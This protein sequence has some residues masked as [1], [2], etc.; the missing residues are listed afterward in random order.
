MQLDL[1]TS[2][3]TRFSLSLE[4]I[5]NVK[6][7]SFKAL[8][9]KL[10]SVKNPQLIIIGGQEG[11]FKDELP[12][13]ALTELS[14][15]AMVLSKEEL[16]KY[17]PHFAEIQSH[18]PDML[19]VFTDDLANLLL[20]NLENEAI[21]KQ[22]NVVLKASLV[23]FEKIAKKINLFKT[24]NFDIR[25][26]ISAIHKMFSYLNSEE[27][28]E[29]MLS[30]GKPASNIS[31]QHHDKNFEAI[32]STL[33]KLNQNEL[34][35]KVEIYKVKLLEK[36]G[37][38]NTEIVALTSDKDKFMAVFN[39]EL[40]RDFTDVEQMYL[41]DKA[42]RVLNQKTKREAN[43]LEKVRFDANFKL[44]LDGKGMNG[45]RKENLSKLKI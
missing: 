33:N 1:I 8:I 4:Q 17:H 35:D 27:N 32:E 28:Y 40:H 34:L 30:E 13:I 22:L 36:N 21:E 11:S 26:K 44:I 12:K 6:L 20:S 25:V 9:S 45:M 10:K 19:R 5:E 42:Q 7:L 24:N 37:V 18:Y 43:F 38:F 15:N 2:L 41:K 3:H 23:D 31:K 14:N 16:R 39:E 29:R